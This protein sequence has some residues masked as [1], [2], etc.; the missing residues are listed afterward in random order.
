MGAK[1]GGIPEPARFAVKCE[2]SASGKH[3]PQTFEKKVDGQHIK[4]KM[5]T[6]C[7]GTLK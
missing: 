6:S 2:K 7:G 4:Y 5:C 3:T 1:T